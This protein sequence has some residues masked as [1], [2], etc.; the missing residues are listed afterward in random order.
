MTNTVQNPTPETAR[1]DRTFRSSLRLGSALYHVDRLASELTAADLIISTLLGTMTK[2]QRVKVAQALE[3]AN[4]PLGL[5]WGI[6][7][8]PRR[9]ERKIAI[10]MAGEFLADEPK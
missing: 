3:S 2:Q 10:D 7:D 4:V 5:D 9:I 1:D 8:N 6:S